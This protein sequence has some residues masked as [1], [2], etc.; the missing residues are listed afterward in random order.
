MSLLPGM[1]GSGPFPLS[2]IGPPNPLLPNP[3][4]LNPF[5]TLIFLSLLRRI[6]VNLI[7]PPQSLGFLKCS[8]KGLIECTGNLWSLKKSKRVNIVKGEAE[9]EG[10]RLV[11]PL[12]LSPLRG[13]TE[14]WVLAAP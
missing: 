13:Q 12:N 3:H 9:P 4:P 6:K 14:T 5:P 7:P 2:R 11:Y 8:R 1:P 10:E